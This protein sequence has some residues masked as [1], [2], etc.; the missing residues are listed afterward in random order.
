M[1]IWSLIENGDINTLFTQPQQKQ[2]ED[3]FTGRYGE[4]FLLQEQMHAHIAVSI[5]ANYGYRKS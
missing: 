5:E 2:T 4:F 3:Y 1:C